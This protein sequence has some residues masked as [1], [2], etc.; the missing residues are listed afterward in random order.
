MET[1][2]TYAI[3]VIQKDEQLSEDYRHFEHPVFLFPLLQKYEC[4]P[5]YYD[6]PSREE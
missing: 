6:L 2:N 5:D 3:R 4:A 1:G